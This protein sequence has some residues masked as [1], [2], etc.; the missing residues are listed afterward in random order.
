MEEIINSSETDMQKGFIKLGGLTQVFLFEIG[1]EL[2]V[3]WLEQHSGLSAALAGTCRMVEQE[4]ERC[5]PPSWETVVSEE[6]ELSKPFDDSTL[7]SSY[8]AEQEAYSAARDSVISVRELLDKAET[9]MLAL[10][11]AAL[12]LL[13]CLAAVHGGFF[14]QRRAHARAFM[15][16]LLGRKI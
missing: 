8:L 7:R 1:A 9:G 13:P 5:E 15:F 11:L 2:C 14:T 10:L 6:A 12:L 3:A 4:L 16:E